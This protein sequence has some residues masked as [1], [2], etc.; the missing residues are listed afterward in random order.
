MNKFLYVFGE[1]E[2]DALLLLGYNLLKS[3]TDRNI[4]VFADRNDYRFDRNTIKAIS[5]DTLTF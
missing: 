5:S 3:N 2:R 1:T 4:Y